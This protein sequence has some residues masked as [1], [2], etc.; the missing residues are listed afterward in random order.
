MHLMGLGFNTYGAFS[1]YMTIK[2]TA[3]VFK[4]PDNVSDKAASLCEPLAVA[5]NGIDLSN[6]KPGQT[7]VVFAPGPIGLLTIQL[8]KAAG[9]V[10]I[11]VTGTSA[12]VARLEI[13]VMIGADA[14]I[15]VDKE[16][17][18]KRGNE[19]AGKL[20]FVFEATEIAS[21][22][23]QGLKMLK[24][25]GKVMIT[26]IHVE[27][28]TFD[29]IDLVRL[30]KSLIGVYAYHK[31]T[32]KRALTLMS[33]VIIDITPIISHRLLFSRGPEGF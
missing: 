14:V 27:D 7:V 22:I 33:S 28:V 10:Y 15:V 2:G 1:E 29:P 25:G 19:I 16:D 17:P 30:S 8:L 4:I 23:N 31:D 12:D 21:T 20:Y 26:R 24:Q 11:I 6:I 18:V 9:A 3:E 5:L 13:A 32:W